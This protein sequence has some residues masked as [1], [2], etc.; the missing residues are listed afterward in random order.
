ME[1]E[2]KGLDTLRA[3]RTGQRARNRSGLSARVPLRRLMDIYTDAN[4]ADNSEGD[5]S[6]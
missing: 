3:A 6:Q 5:T 4:M 2:V 1:F